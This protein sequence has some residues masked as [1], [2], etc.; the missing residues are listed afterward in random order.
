MDRLRCTELSN[1]RKLVVLWL[2]TTW[3]WGVLS[4]LQAS[5]SRRG[6]SEITKLRVGSMGG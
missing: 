5:L 6:C 4:A 3:D 2:R 1:R